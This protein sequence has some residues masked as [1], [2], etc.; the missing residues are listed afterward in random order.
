MAGS[1]KWFIYSSDTDQNY[2]IQAD[3]SNVEALMGEVQDYLN[4][5]TI[6]EGLPRNV[7]AR[8]AV[9]ENDAG[10]RAISIP[11]LTKTVYN[12]L[13]ANKAEIDD[14]I[15]SGTEKLKLSR[16]VPE[17]IKLPKAQDTGLNDGD[18]T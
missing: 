2:A 9:Y 13:R 11:V 18:A 5:S 1:R 8:R 16:L 7:T 14:P 6:T 15:G 4:T 3:E 12:G 10:T 17:K